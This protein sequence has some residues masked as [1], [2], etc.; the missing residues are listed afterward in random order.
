MMS[1]IENQAQ[2]IH[3]GQSLEVRVGAHRF[4][5]RVHHVEGRLSVK[6]ESLIAGASTRLK[7]GKTS[8][9]RA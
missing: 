8:V 5:K 7:M 2:P 6:V 3:T 4:S 1:W 9:H